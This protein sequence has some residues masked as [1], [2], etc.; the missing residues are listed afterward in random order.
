VHIS[1]QPALNNQR[2][3]SCSKRIALPQFHI[4]LFLAALICLTCIP[5]SAG[6]RHQSQPT[7]VDFGDVTVETSSTRTV[8][9]TNLGHSNATIS[10][11]TVTGSGFNYMGPALPLTL[12]R[13]QSVNLTISF[14][15]SAAGVSS[16]NLSL[17]TSGNVSPN[18]VPLTGTGVQSQQTLLLTVSPQSVSFGNVPVGSNGSQTVSLLNTGNGPVNVSQA[19]MAGNG[20]GMSG[21][22]VPMTLGPGQ[23]TA[24]TVSFAPAGAGSASG[25]ISVVSNAAN[26]VSTVALSGMGVQPQISAAPGSVSFGT[27]TVGQ[28]SSQAVTLT[29]AGGAP[30]NITQLAGPGT[31]FSLTGLA[32]PL[33]LAPG[34]STA[35]TVS[36]TPTSGASS[37]SS[38]MLMSNAPTSPTTI[39]LSG[40]GS[41]QVLQ[42]TPSTTALSFGNQTLNASATQSV[43]LTNTGNSAVSISQVNV[44]GTGFSLNG[45]APLVTLSAGQA[46]SFSVTFTPTV[47]G[48]ATGSASV[49]STAANSPLSISLAG[50][51]VQPQIS[52]V[53]GSV[54]F[55]TVTVGQTNSQ[56]ITLS[57]PGTANLTVTQ[58]AGPGT[59]FGLTGLA[60]PLTLAPGKSTAFTV[61]FTPTSGTNSS[62]SLTLISNAP[63]SPTTIPLS[64]TGLAPVLQLTP[65]TTS[66]SFGSQA[67]NASATQGV[68]LTNTG[69][70]AVSIS[71]VNVTGTGFTLSGSAPLVTLSAGQAA[72]FSV[73]FTPTA[74]GSD[75]GSASVV[76]TAANSPLSISLSG[77]GAQPHFVSLAWSETSSGVVGYN[78]Y[79]STQPSGPYSRLNTAPVATMA[80]TDNTVQSG[81]T[82]YY[83][84]TALDSSGDE[85]AFS[86]DVAVTIP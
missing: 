3:R 30:L 65:S 74:A 2:S 62:S 44:A 59:G 80:Y 27:V 16:G 38:L 25:N 41:A 70:A 12:S 26:S 77:S 49:V 75:A 10:A 66:L 58:S 69:N 61:S 52:V 6:R 28:T 40:A 32:L 60:L 14:A 71:Q 13:G 22:A 48:N 33:T 11:A 46:A 83:W 34:K 64:G 84:I 55:G 85:S 42:L 7:G 82:Y 31:G 9:V 4:G 39:P 29:N 43:T 78:V 21:L 23:S 73:T 53:P 47:A 35:F 72:S 17:S 5:A 24:F 57:N 18:S 86:S 81:Q 8:V 54:S 20:F 50:V 36:F 51:G 68:T 56:T 15:P 37:S 67:L 19:T 63:N 1:R 76:S 45:S 79:S